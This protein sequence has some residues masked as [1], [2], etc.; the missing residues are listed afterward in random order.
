VGSGHYLL[1][2]SFPFYPILLPCLLPLFI[3]FPLLKEICFGQSGSWNTK[4]EH[5][6]GKNRS[7]IFEVVGNGPI[8][9]V[10][11]VAQKW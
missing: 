11:P 4:T 7:K 1:I 9:R 5:T 2:V 10:K 6:Q 8:R 3:T